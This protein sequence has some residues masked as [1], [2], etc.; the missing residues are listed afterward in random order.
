MKKS[1]GKRTFQKNLE[2]NLFNFTGKLT[3]KGKEKNKIQK[4]NI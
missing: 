2:D 3:Q 4:R 1:K